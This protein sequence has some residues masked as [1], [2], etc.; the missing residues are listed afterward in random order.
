MNIIERAYQLAQSGDC[1][2]MVEIERALSREGFAN[3]LAHM[4]GPSLRKDLT[5][6]CREAAAERKS[7]A[8]G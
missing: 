7:S 8:A 3:V 4:S 2:S 1:V 5:R 6:M